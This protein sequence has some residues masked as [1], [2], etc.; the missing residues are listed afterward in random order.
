[1]VLPPDDD[2]ATLSVTGADFD[3]PISLATPAEPAPGAAAQAFQ[4]L[5]ERHLASNG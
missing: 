1:M 5:V 4:H 2:L 3:W